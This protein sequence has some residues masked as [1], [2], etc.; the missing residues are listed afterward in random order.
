MVDRVGR[1]RSMVTMFVLV[2]TFLSALAWNQSST[3]TTALLVGSRMCAFAA[4][5][6]ACI[7]A[8]EVIPFGLDY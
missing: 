3:V 7:F 2:F 5:T 4:F 6:V 1:K 8:P